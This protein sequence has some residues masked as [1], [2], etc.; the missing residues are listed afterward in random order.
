MNRLISSQEQ[1]LYNHLLQC[2]EVENP[3]QLIERFRCLF[4]HG[5][6]YPDAD[7][8]KV[9]EQLATSEVA[10][11]F[12]F[13]L[14]RCCYICINRWQWQPRTQTAI[15][16]LIALFDIPS[17]QVYCRIAKRLQE[18]VQG[19]VQTDLYAALQ[20]LARVMQ[21]PPEPNTHV[22]DAP[23]KD[24]IHRYPYLYDHCLLTSSSTGE[25]QQVI[26]QLRTQRQGQF[27][28]DLSKYIIGQIRQSQGIGKFNNADGISVVPASNP[29]LLSNLELDAAL[30][31]F[32]GGTYRNAAQQFTTYSRTAHSYHQ[33]KDDFYEYLTAA[34]DPR[35]GKRYF[36]DQLYAQLQNILLDQDAA[37]LNHSLIVSTCRRLLNF[38]VVSNSERVQH[39]VLVDLM[40]N[41]GVTSTIG[42]LL[43]IVLFC[44]GSK[45]YLE[46]LFAIL[47]QHYQRH[48]TNGVDWLVKALENLNV[49]F[50]T[51]FGGASVMY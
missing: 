25:Q 39:F 5:R 47:F 30:K 3:Q 19:F 12:P 6:G 33:F 22:G 31:Q 16:E 9:V 10:E 41:L 48:T 35:Y 17:K 20:L 43:K 24:L 50:S 7:I 13:I 21:R 28:L 42:L 40:S 44:G 11:N 1:K 38:L 51:H 34:I 14:N 29:T 26:R 45:S 32:A 23:L 4:L 8:Q 37:A 27:D 15:A 18:L 2:V 49:A 36:N 46:K